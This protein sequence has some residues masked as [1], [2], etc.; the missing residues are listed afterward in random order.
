MLINIRQSFRQRQKN[1][2][3]WQPHGTLINQLLQ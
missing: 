2:V 3:R 1:I